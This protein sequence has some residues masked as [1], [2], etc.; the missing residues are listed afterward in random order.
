M[1]PSVITEDAGNLP[2]HQNFP[3]LLQSFLGRLACSQL[4]DMLFLVG[5]AIIVKLVA[6]EVHRR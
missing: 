3:Y 6:W 5:A 2:C 1:L 4:V